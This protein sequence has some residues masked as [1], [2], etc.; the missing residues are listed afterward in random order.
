MPT[1]KE[2][3]RRPMASASI[4]EG[5]KAIYRN[6]IRPLEEAYGF[7]LYQGPLTDVDLEAKPIVLVLGQ[8]STGKTSMLE[9]LLGGVSYPGSHI[10]PEPTTDKFMAITSGSTERV[11]P[12]HAATAA[13]DLPFTGLAQFGGAFMS[14]FHVAQTPSS[15]FL[16]DN[17]I[18]VDTP[19]VLSGDQQR[20]GRSYDFVKVCEWFST[21][22]DLIL[23]LFDAHK[24]DISDEFKRVII[25]ALRGNEDKVRVVLNKSDVVPLEELL[26]VYGA[27]MWSLGKIVQTPEVVRVYVSS[28]RAFKQANAELL[29]REE[30]ELLN[31]IEALPRHAA[32]RKVNELIKRARQVRVHAYMMGHVRSEMPGWFGSKTAAKTRLLANLDAEVKLVQTRHSLPRGDFP[33][34]DTL[35]RMLQTVE[36][37]KLP[38]LSLRQMA[39]L[40]DAIARDLPQLMH[41]HPLTQSISFRPVINPFSGECLQREP[42]ANCFAWDSIDQ[43]RYRRLWLDLNLPPPAPTRND[44]H[45]GG[46]DGEQRIPGA[47]ARNLLKAS[48]LSTEQ[49]A[50]VWRWADRDLDGQL[51]FDEF[52]IAMHAIE[53]VKRGVPLPEPFPLSLA[54][55]PP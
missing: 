5:L 40:E 55:P 29:L 28:F 10:G 23:L 15:S 53:L 26:R 11:V 54:P 21:R 8:Y 38:R 31:E 27:L 32:L 46:G 25:E 34:L 44:L 33:S 45:G 17:L 51:T 22:A 39:A 18:L 16:L 7:D 6:Q 48:E 9:Y 49:L 50:H 14:K 43:E 52:C 3:K 2:K 4:I 37:G 47:L 41:R 20:L 13:S 35:D 24:L 30:A 1:V 19:G 12:G 42:P 36:L